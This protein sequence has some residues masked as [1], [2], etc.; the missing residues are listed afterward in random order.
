MRTMVKPVLMVLM[1]LVLSGA[2]LG[3]A[4]HI[5]PIR[6]N[7]SGK[8]PIAVL[9]VRNVNTQASVMQVKVMSWS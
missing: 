3:E 9:T 1:G 7:L 8:T 2:V 6:I 4:F 5:S